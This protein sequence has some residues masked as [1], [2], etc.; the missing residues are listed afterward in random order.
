MCLELLFDFSWNNGC[1][2]LLSVK[3]LEA[4]AG[5]PRIS[6]HLQTH[7]SSKSNFSS[8]LLQVSQIPNCV[9]LKCIL[10]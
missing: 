6:V 10:F 9:Q 7:W 4:E 2:D 8:I 3:T 1:L 5:T